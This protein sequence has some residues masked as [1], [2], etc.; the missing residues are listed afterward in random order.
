MKKRK[1]KEGKKLFKHFF[2]DFA[3]ATGAIPGFIWL[4]P[5]YI[6]KSPEAKKRIK[7][8]ALVVSNHI[9]FYDP[10]YLLFAI[11]YRRQRFVCMKELYEF[12]WARRFFNLAGCIPID[13]E[14][15]NF[16]SM[17]EIIGALKNGEIVTL[18]PEGHINE[19]STAPEAFKS[20]VVLMS[21]MSGKPIIPVY[22]SKKPGFG[23]LTIVKGEALDPYS[24]YGKRPSSAQFGEIAELLR[25]KEHDLMELC[26]EKSK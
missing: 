9:S 11:W 7:G 20:G 10:V 12:P 2:Y 1:K 24:I 17:R 3:M 21:V 18:F 26:K 19:E 5:K 14:N 25:Q 13:R 15:T 6:Y 22:I 4:H 8:G 23:G 16:D